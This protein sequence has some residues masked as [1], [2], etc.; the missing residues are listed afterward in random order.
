MWTRQKIRH[1]LRSQCH[2][3]NSSKRLSATNDDS[4]EK[5]EADDKDY[6]KTK[7][8]TVVATLHVTTIDATKDTGT[9]DI[10]DAAATTRYNSR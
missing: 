8:T 10:T 3:Q 2:G 7:L 1:E 4:D 9:T 6:G 5:D